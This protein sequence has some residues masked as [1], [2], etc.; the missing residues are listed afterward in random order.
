MCLFYPKIVHKSVLYNSAKTTCLKKI[1]F[2]S[3]GL[4]YLQTI[5]LHYYLII[6][7]SPDQELIDRLEVLCDHQRMVTSKTTTFV[8]LASCASHLI[9]LQDTLIINI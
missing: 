6:N 2:D 4:K 7:I 1:L 5:R 9:R 8:R 3:Y